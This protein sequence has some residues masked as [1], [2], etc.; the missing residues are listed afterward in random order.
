MM[1]NE[2]HLDSMSP[3]TKR[4]YTDTLR[5][6]RKIVVDKTKI[7]EDYGDDKDDLIFIIHI[8]CCV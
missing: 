7:E 4:V 5:R 8:L 6:K 3:D 1:T 2:K